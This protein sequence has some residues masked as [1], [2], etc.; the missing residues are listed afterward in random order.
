MKGKLDPELIEGMNKN[1]LDKLIDDLECYVV[2]M[3][4]QADINDTIDNLR[5]F[6]PRKKGK[7]KVLGI[8]GTAAKEI[9]FMSNTYWFI[10]FG[11]FILGAY[12]IWMNDGSIINSKN[13]Y[14]SAVILSPIPFILG[15][16][17]VFRGREEGVIEL[18][19]ACKISI[20]EIMFSRLIIICIYNILLNTVL[21]IVLVYF[22]SG[23]LL[24]RMTLM[25]LAPFTVIS[26]IGLILVS[27]LRGSYVAAIFTG[28]WMV[29]IMAVLTQKKV[30]DRLI[31]INI[32][33]YAVLTIIG[34]ILVITQIKE[35]SHRDSSFFKRSVLDEAKN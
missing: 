23:I 27:R 1:D 9:G 18:E 11:L 25:W 20:G 5:E 33:V 12:S 2:K 3:P 15:I 6:V 8:I 19:L 35:Y 21:S 17:E 7:T 22:N 26:G 4:S 30:M 14:I 32:S 34:I 29:L 10:S 16:I 28:V 31:G 13:P 24:L